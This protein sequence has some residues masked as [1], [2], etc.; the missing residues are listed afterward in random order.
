VTE[1]SEAV[2]HGTLHSLGGVGLV[3]MNARY[4]SDIEDVWSALT[5]PERL[6]RWYGTVQGDLRSGGEFTAHIPMSGWDG[7]G[8]IEACDSPRYLRLTMWEEAGKETVVTATLSADGDDTS[9]AIE[10]RGV[11]VDFAWAYGT[12]WHRHAESLAVHLAG[13][14]Y[15][16]SETRWDELEP[17]YR[18]MSVESIDET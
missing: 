15:V 11:P 18:A 1:D 5:I 2:I 17:I 14:E 7:Q 12:G 6:A 8:R 10:V 3:R 13:G 9:L 4:E 16:K